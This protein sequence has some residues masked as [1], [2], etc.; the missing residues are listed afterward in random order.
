MVVVIVVFNGK[1]SVKIIFVI[2]FVD[3]KVF[4]NGVKKGVG[5][6]K[7]GVKDILLDVVI[8]FERCNYDEFLEWVG[9]FKGKFICLSIKG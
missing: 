7:Y 8:V 6:Y 2:V 9:L 5:G 4:L 1:L 3:D